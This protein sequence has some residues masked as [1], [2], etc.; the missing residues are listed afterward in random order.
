[1]SIHLPQRHRDEFRLRLR[2]HFAVVRKAAGNIELAEFF[3]QPGGI[4]IGHRDDLRLR[5]REPHRVKRVAVIPAPRMP[6][7]GDAHSPRRLGGRYC[8]GETGGTGREE[9][10]TAVHEK[11]HC[12]RDHAA[13][14]F[15]AADV[16]EKGA[17]L[18]PDGPQ[19]RRAAHRRLRSRAAGRF[20]QQREKR[21]GRALRHRAESRRRE[22]LR[23]RTGGS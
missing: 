23:R 22:G 6:D 21:K 18:G 12:D 17:M 9:K 11:R 7:D 19:D 16:P 8:A 15:L 10:A 14:F 5:K 4:R 20:A 13:E 3:R 2:K 1:M